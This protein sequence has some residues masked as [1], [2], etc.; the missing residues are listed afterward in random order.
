M[1]SDLQKMKKDMLIV[2]CLIIFMFMVLSY[3]LLYEN[4]K[5]Q[6]E[7]LIN[8]CSGLSDVYEDYIQSNLDQIKGLINA[9]AAI[10]GV[11]KLNKTEID[12]VCQIIYP[13]HQD[14][15]ANILILDTEGNVVKTLTGN[16]KNLKDSACFQE[17]MKGKLVVSRKIDGPI[18]REPVV[19]VAGPIYDQNRIAGAIIESI[20]IDKFGRMLD[21]IKLD[22]GGYIMIFDD[23]GKFIYHPRLQEATT[24]INLKSEKFFKEIF[25]GNKGV[26]EAYS[27]VDRQTVIYS[28]SPIRDTRW[29]I[30]AVQPL[31]PII[32][33]IKYTLLRNSLVFIGLLILSIML[34]QIYRISKYEQQFESQL[35]L[36]RLT[37]TNQLAAGIAH[38]IRN[39]LCAIK[40][41]VQMMKLKENQA[42]DPR[43]LQLIIDDLDRIEAISNEFVQLAKPAQSEVTNCDINEI[44][45]EV[46]T[47]LEAQA[48]L[49]KVKITSN[50]ANPLP[51]IEGCP[52]QLKQVFINII[53]N[54]IEALSQGGT[55]KIST[56]LA[57]GGKSI[58]IAIK[59][60]G[61]GIHKETLSRLGQPF[62]STKE[63][64]TGLGLMLCFQ[65]IKH[66]KAD[67]KIHTHPKH[68]TEFEI[69]IPI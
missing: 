42:P 69:D 3:F 4:I 30:V 35:Q 28:Y 24:A 6:R 29:G 56:K 7:G 23:R 1:P 48:N 31:Y 55:I 52:N 8:E 46:K 41:L 59:D 50:L 15:L 65:I 37:T 10:D 22:H 20:S 27:P 13:K 38:E 57:D 12:Q 18:T 66:H 19:I 33:N 34:I 25:M 60:N 14:L 44:L 32:E 26:L 16:F 64:G 47:L 39:P 40:C 43:T 36:E 11:K 17:A 62:I 9:I 2:I 5:I 49:A 45:K 63:K 51:T 54:A 61:P 67:L 21:K 53:K 68:G 58:R